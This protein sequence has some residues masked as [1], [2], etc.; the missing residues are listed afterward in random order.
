M[1][2]LGPSQEISVQR[3]N[4][5]GWET[6]SGLGAE[7]RAASV[8]ISESRQE[9]PADTEDRHMS[10][11]GTPQSPPHGALVKKW[12]MDQARLSVGWQLAWRAQAMKR[13][14]TPCRAETGA[15][16][17][18]CSPSRCPRPP[19]PPHTIVAG[20]VLPTPKLHPCQ[21]GSLR[22]ERS[23]RSVPS[24]MAEGRPDATT[25]HAPPS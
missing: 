16:R 3:E 2:A 10:R 23:C 13:L 24:L 11:T 22:M 20:K 25:S 21:P 15:T 8:S 7:D 14:L 19:R 9:E 18:P 5:P 1:Q 12:Q 6:I 17:L 4:T